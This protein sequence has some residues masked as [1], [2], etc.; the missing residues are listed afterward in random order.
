[1]TLEDELTS[2][3]AQGHTAEVSRLLQAGAQV[4]G[5][6]RF[7]RSAVQVMMMG[8]TPVA[9]V[10]LRH[11]ADPNVAD[12]RTGATPLHDAAR[13]GFLDTV[14]LLVNYK[15]D[16]RAKDKANCQPIDLARKSGL[17]DVVAYLECVL[18]G[19]SGL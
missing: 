16:P 12:R 15:A 17:T 11:G 19:N 2:A 18:S 6:N 7:G 9:E 14:R 3:A 8:S 5:V 4:N 13:A 1:M 10:L